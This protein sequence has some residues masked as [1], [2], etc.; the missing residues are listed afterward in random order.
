MPN[1][2]KNIDPKAKPGLRIKL[3]K[4]HDDPRPVDDD[5]EGVIDHVDS[6]GTIHVEWDNGRVLG[7]IPNHDEYILYPQSDETI[8]DL[9]SFFE[10]KAA[11]NR[12]MPKPTLRGAKST[13]AG[14]NVN[15]NFKSSLSKT[16]PK[17]RDI[18]VE[19]EEIE[20][21][22]SDNMTVK[23]LSKK[24]G[25]SVKDIQKELKVGIKIEM[26]HTKNK[27]TAREIVMDHISEFP[28]YYTNPKYGTI[29]SEKGLEKIHEFFGFGGKKN[30]DDQYDTEKMTNEVKRIVSSIK[31]MKP[32]QE[33]SIKKMIENF[34]NRYSEHSSTPKIMKS[35]YH[36]L[37]TK[38]D[39]IEET[40]TAGGGGA[41]AF[42]GPLNGPVKKSGVYEPK[43]E[44]RVIKV[45]DLL[46]EVDTKSSKLRDNSGYADGRPWAGD[47]DNDGWHFDDVPVWKDGKI[48]DILSKSGIN[49]KDHNLSVNVNESK[50]KK[51]AYIKF[52]KGDEEG[53]ISVELGSKNHT[54]IINGLVDLGFKFT[55]ISK[56]EYDNYDEGDEITIEELYDNNKEELEETTTF[57]S[58]WGGNG[59]PVTPTFATKK[60]KH[61]QSKNPIYKGGT[62]IQK[63]KNG[64]VMS[65]DNKIK[66][67]KGGK[68]VKIKDKCAKYNNNEHCSSGA[69]DN[70]LELSDTTFKN[71]QEVSKKLRITKE[72]VIERLKTKLNK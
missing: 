28:D 13:T 53:V 6:L 25:V 64:G 71:I 60:G 56:S 32:N 31:S 17:V 43:N 41:G 33:S 51:Y 46:K 45:K 52:K 23:D 44:N 27:S 36:E 35:L 11:I 61:K 24:H 66:W 37:D 15:K 69:I 48:V 16:N 58:V 38:F 2:E 54:N 9:D 8:D 4:M 49:W 29:A 65:E 30:K 26:E 1:I 40:T 47:K 68:F 63:I 72:E 67:V 70:P 50:E 22:E 55:K 59:M 20:G 21:G 3:I 7:V 34:R 57:G 14:K 42:V 62:I 5:M 12:S 18:K 10:S 19:D 39:E